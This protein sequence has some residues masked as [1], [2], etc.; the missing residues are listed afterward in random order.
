MPASEPRRQTGR[1]RLLPTAT[2][3][4]LHVDVDA[5]LASVEIAMHP[6]LT[7]KCVVIGG[8]PGS[9][10]IVISSSYEARAFGVRPG[11]PLAEAKRRCPHAIFRKGSSQEANR[12]RGELT[13]L[14]LEFTP[15]IAVT[16]VDDFLLDL[17]DAAL[18]HGDAASTAERIHLAARER[19]HLPLSIGVGTNPLLA[20]L[21][22]KIAKPGRV[23]ELLPGL[24]DAWLRNLPVNSLPGVGHSIGRHLA[25]FSIR[26]VGDLRHVSRELLYASFGRPGLVLF[27]RCRGIDNSAVDASHW[28]D[29]AGQLASRPPKS[30]RRES[31]F[32]PEEAR[33]DLVEAML[34]YLVE[35]AAAKLRSH[36]Q[37]VRSL[38]VTLRYVDTRTQKQIDSSPISSR[39]LRKQRKLP[40]P[41]DATLVLVEHARKILTELPRRRALVKRV[42]VAFHGLA[43]TGG[44]QGNLFNDNTADEEHAA[45][46][47]RHRRIDSAVDTLREKLGFGLVLRGSCLPLIET[48]PLDEDGFELRT[49]SL[50]Q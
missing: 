18:L 11:I 46:D 1:D 9:R 36:G 6:E 26:T 21:A 2:R 48:H 7:G 47:D 8:S 5:F 34:A 35:R 27:E 43:Q 42:G 20:R 13:R 24:E 50:N 25:R 4:I 16:S 29:D 45:R 15:R 17:T 41:T 32:E 37:V 40:R 44:W 3:R 10:N 28:V 38:E 33:F 19:L 14:L 49:P 31:T 22:G 30:I 23:A 12:L 39:T